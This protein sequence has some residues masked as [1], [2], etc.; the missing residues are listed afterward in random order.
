MGIFLFE[1]IIYDTIK[2]LLGGIKI[3]SNEKNNLLGDLNIK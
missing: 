2:L 3:K 1:K